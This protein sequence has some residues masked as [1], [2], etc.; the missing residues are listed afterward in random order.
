MMPRVFDARRLSE[1]EVRLLPAHR[2]RVYDLIEATEAIVRRNE[3]LSRQEKMLCRILVMGVAKNIVARGADDVHGE[4]AWLRE[5]FVINDQMRRI[6]NS[7]KSHADFVDYLQCRPRGAEH[8]PLVTAIVAAAVMLSQPHGNVVALHPYGRQSRHWF[9]H[10]KRLLESM[11]SDTRWGYQ[12]LGTHENEWYRLLATHTGDRAVVT[13][14][15]TTHNHQNIRGIGDNL[16]FLVIHEARCHEQETIR[17]ILPVLSSDA[18]VVMLSPRAR[19][20]EDDTV[21]NTGNGLE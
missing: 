12:W 14:M 2:R 4:D 21:M 5:A 6:V 20:P 13:T 19:A 11:Q 17:S 15:G 3:C 18:K 10:V 7:V 9:A 1:A 16:A 8:G